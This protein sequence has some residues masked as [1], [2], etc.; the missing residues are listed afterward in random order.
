MGNM[1][2]GKR[3]SLKML[4][5]LDERYGWK[6]P[7]EMRSTVMNGCHS[8]LLLHAIQCLEDSLP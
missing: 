5:V 7:P 8:R 4:T 6:E 1:K 3:E 2:K